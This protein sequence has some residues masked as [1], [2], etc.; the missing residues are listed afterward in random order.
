MYAFITSS[1]FREDV[2]RPTF[3]NLNGFIDRIRQA[4]PEYPRCLYISADPTR[5]DL[6]C[7][8]G[9]DIFMAFANAGIHFESYQV[10]DDSNAQD[11]AQMVADCNFIMLGGGHVPTQN[12]FLQ[13]IDLRSLLS[14]FDGVV[15]GISAGAMNCADIVYAQPEESGE[16]S[17]DFQRFLPGLGLCKVNILPHYQKVKDNILDGVRMFEDVIYKD[18]FDHSLIALPDF[19]Y[20]ISDGQQHLLC[21]ESYRIRNGILEKL[22]DH[23]QTLMIDPL[24]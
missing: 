7:R 16:S 18:T 11:A 4:L 20:V 6:N 21:G 14:G 12:A 24:I 23:G 10:L 15:M 1:P 17:P 8:W 2:D 19:S 3:S 13:R 9:A 22:T 5:H